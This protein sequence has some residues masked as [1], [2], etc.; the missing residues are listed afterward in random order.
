MQLDTKKIGKQIF[1]RRLQQKMKQEELCQGICSVSYLSKL[2]NGKI[3]ASKEILQLLCTRLEIAVTD[4]RDIEAEVKEK[5]DEWQKAF[6]Y[7]D[8]KKIEQLYIELSKEIKQVSDFDIC[9]YYYLLHIRYLLGKANVS[10]AEEQLEKLKKAYKKYT[11]LQQLLYT[12]NQ[13]LLYCLQNKWR[14]ALQ[15]L[16]ETE[17]KARELKYDETGIYYNLALAYSQL[18]NSYLAL[19][20]ANIAME[21]FRDEC[22]VLNVLHCRTIIAINYMKS[23]QYEEALR[24]Y[25]NIL[26]EAEAF[27]EKDSIYGITLHNI[28]FVY[29]KQQKYEQAKELYLQSLQYKKDDTNYITT[30]YE[31]A[32]QCMYLNEMKEAR[33][34]ID[35]GIVLAEKDVKN[36]KLLLLLF[37][38]KYK[39]FEQPF[40]YKEFL[41][42]E[43]IPFFSHNGELEELKK[44]YI[45]LA[46]YFEQ[47]LNF[48]KSNNYY[49]LAIS[50]LERGD[51]I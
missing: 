33:K 30:I 25:E 2:E 27:S 43:A 13:G 23:G 26:R 35:E 41:E 45:E 21:K 14:Q 48:E 3:E 12:Y 36:K 22:K 49:K 51:I 24:N 46:E 37:M 7:Q 39:Y 42:N 8:R 29:Y 44:A 11:P 28:G 38:L 18:K 40:L 50:I 17:R 5:L 34:W 4:L 6:R 16:I 31:I 32:V 9:N 19:Y 1:Y 47:E 10:E 15:H 20:F